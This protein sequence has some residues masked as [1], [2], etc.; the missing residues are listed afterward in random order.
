MNTT[1]LKYSSSYLKKRLGGTIKCLGFVSCK[2]KNKKELL[3]TR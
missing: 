3:K 2:N 1:K